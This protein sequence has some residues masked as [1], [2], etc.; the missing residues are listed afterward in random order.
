MIGNLIHKLLKKNRAPEW[1]CLDMKNKTPEAEIKN[2]IRVKIREE[3]S[4]RGYNL[5]LWSDE[6]IN[7]MTGLY[8]KYFDQLYMH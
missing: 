4:A 2:K 8:Y 5:E 3:V 6:F 1:F 7:K